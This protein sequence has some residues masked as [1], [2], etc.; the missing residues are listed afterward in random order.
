MSA[1]NR[2]S[3]RARSFGFVSH[4]EEGDFIL[5]RTG[6]ALEAFEWGEVLSSD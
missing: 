4:A 2:S 6:K 3:D 5:H 1:R